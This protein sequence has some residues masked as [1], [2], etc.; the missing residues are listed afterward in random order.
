MDK[1]I[2]GSVP[3]TN[4]I[5]LT[6]FLPPDLIQ[7][8]YEVPSVLIKKFET[9]Q[10]DVALL[11]VYEVFKNPNYSIIPAACIG[12]HGPV[13]SVK[14]FFNGPLG[15][16]KKV[17]LDKHSVTSNH[18]LQVILKKFYGLTP[19]WMTE[20]TESYQGLLKIGDNALTGDFKNFENQ[21]DLGR[22]WTQHTQTSF[23]YPVWVTQT[24]NLNGIHHV[25]YKALQ[26]GL[27]SIQEIV[28]Q[29]ASQ[30]IFPRQMIEEYFK[31]NLRY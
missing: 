14:F 11:P 20:E 23:V 22:E 30:N 6:H 25:L 16:I 13:Q 2:I 15:Q 8:Q 27:N 7:V 4:S 28:N 24:A 10:Y 12:S 26:N 1:L 31:I 3:Y 9:K 5:P 19:Q 21:I 17:L 18:L 29:L